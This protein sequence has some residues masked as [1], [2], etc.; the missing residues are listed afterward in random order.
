V[1]S[2]GCA[3]SRDSLLS[4][5]GVFVV[6]VVGGGERRGESSPREVGACAP[7]AQSRRGGRGDNAWDRRGSIASRRPMREAAR[8]AEVPARAAEA[9]GGAA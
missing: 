5:L 1:R 9:T 6:I 8:A 2:F 7:L 3:S 4:V